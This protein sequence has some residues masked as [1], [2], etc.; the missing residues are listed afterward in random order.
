[1][2]GVLSPEDGGTAASYFRDYKYADLIGAKTGTAQVNL[3]DI[4]NNAWFVSFAPYDDPEIA[5]VVFIANGYTGGV[6]SLTCKDVVSNYME[7][8][9]NPDI[10][11]MP[12]QDSFVP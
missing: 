8:K 5:I 6:A 7:R 4:E 9:N 2:K 3:I 1:M 11:R 10:D 12:V